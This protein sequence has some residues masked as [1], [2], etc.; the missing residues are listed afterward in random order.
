MKNYTHIEKIDS[1]ELFEEVSAYVDA[2]IDEATHCGALAEGAD[3][4]Y[5]LEIGRL[6]RLCAYYEANYLHFDH[7]EF[8]SPLLVSIEQELAKRSI[9]QRQAAAHFGLL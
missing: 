5:T 6:G 4:A 7:I 3:N 8:K 2:L 1:P 9:K